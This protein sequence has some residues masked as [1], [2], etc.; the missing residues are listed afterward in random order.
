MRLWISDVRFTK[1]R[2]RLTHSTVLRGGHLCFIKRLSM[3]F[4]PYHRATAPCH[5]TVIFFAIVFRVLGVL[6]FPVLED[7][8]FRYLWD[9]RMSI[10]LGSPYGLIPSDY[11]DHAGISARFEEILGLINYP[12]IAT[13]YGP[14]NQW[15]FALSYLVAP[16]ES[17]PL[18]SI[19]ALGRYRANLRITKTGKT[20]HGVAICMVTADH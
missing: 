3:V 13:V 16:G 2:R 17:W 10:E 18:Q 12:N 14:T 4:V 9:G 8:I 1:L 11:F 6:A 15:V 5:W 19:Y 20:K 7:D